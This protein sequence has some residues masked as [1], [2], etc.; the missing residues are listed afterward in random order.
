MKHG[1]VIYPVESFTI[2]QKYMGIVF[3]VI[4]NNTFNSENTHVSD[5]LTFKTK[6]LIM[7]QGTSTSPR[8]QVGLHQ[9][10]KSFDAAVT[11]AIGQ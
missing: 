4:Y 6:L 1:P 3:R 9:F 8:F 10:S 5:V 11:K 2:I 7:L